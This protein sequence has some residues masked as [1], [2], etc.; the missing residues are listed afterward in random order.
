MPT[1][2]AQPSG[3]APVPLRVMSF[4]ARNAGAGDGHDGWHNRRP[5]FFQTIA[6]FGPDLLGLQEV[7]AE[8][9][10]DAAAALRPGYALSGVARDD[11]HRAGEWSLIAYR[12]DRFDRLDAGDFWLSPTPDRPS[13]GWDA[14][15]PRTC[16]WVRLRDRRSGRALLFANTHWDH[17]GATARAESAALIK[18]RLPAL[19]EGAA[20]IVVGDLNATEDDEP[21]QSLLR[22]TRPGDVQL[23][24]SYR[25]A[26][27]QRLPT[28]RTFHGFEGG[29]DGSRIDFIFHGPGLRTVAAGID[30]NQ[31]TD[32]EFPSDHYAV[33]AQLIWR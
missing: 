10:D 13:T 18:Q 2:A 19:A 11:G 25:Q 29:L 14:V 1:T 26:H 7:L 28:E 9:H 22:P 30:R 31:G 33:T 23:F 20:V 3:N 12:A 21:L 5:H 32:G 15:C 6:A 24:D 27:P 8:Q 17:V 16:S 4:N